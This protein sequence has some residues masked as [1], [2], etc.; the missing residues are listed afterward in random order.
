MLEAGLVET[1][2]EAFARYLGFGRP[3]YEPKY[4]IAP[5]EAIRLIA[6]AGGLSFIA[7]PGNSMTEAVLTGLIKAGVDGIEVVHPSH[8]AE[9]TAHYR[10]IV[11]EY[12]LLECGGSDFH[13]GKKND[14]EVLGRYYVPDASV[15]AMRRRLH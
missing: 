5:R 4:Q 2:Q 14:E 12:Y 1:Y 7:H 9:L 15:D 13:G 6:G 3:A 8:S 10:G 11:S